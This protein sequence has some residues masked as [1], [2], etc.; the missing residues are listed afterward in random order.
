MV[1]TPYQ[2][3][4]PKTDLSL[5]IR[6][7][8]RQSDVED[9]ISSIRGSMMGVCITVSP[10]LVQDSL[11]DIR[12]VV[13]EVMGQIVTNVSENASTEDRCGHIPIPKE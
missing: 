10:N 5:Q 9:D 2:T 11:I 7:H 1:L 6:F 3:L 12:S 13:K 4:D 8:S